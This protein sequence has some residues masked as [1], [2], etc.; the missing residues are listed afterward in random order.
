MRRLYT[1]VPLILVPPPQRYV[2]NLAQ[3]NTMRTF[4]DDETESG[5]LSFQWLNP[6]P[7]L[8]M[9]EVRFVKDPE[10]TPVSAGVSDRLY[11]CDV[12]FEVKDA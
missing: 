10:F 12:S 7:D 8:G 2:L 4:F 11:E 3:R 5:S 9:V 1:R 6:I